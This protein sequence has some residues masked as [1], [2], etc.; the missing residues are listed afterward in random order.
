LNRMLELPMIKM[1]CRLMI[2]TIIEKLKK[3]FEDTP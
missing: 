2:F 1:A 3:E